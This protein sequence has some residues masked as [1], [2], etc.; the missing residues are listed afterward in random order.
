MI[1][2]SKLIEVIYNDDTRIMERVQKAYKKTHGYAYRN[3]KIINKDKT[4]GDDLF[5]LLTDIMHLC[6]R[7]GYDFSEILS[8]SEVYYK[9]EVESGLIKKI[10]EKN[11]GSYPFFL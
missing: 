6:D 5:E 2:E 7:L 10:I 3:R 11:T 4:I 9:E 8:L 1:N